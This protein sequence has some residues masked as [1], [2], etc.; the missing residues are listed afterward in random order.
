MT[1]LMM[2]YLQKTFFIKHLRT[3]QNIYIMIHY[4]NIQQKKQSIPCTSQAHQ[5]ILFPHQQ[6][7]WI[8]PDK[9]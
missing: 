2:V 5:D 8:D 6:K 3:Q 7:N 1:N 9:L 4:Q